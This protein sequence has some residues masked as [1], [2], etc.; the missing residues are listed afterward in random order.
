LDESE[1]EVK[2]SN[3]QVYWIHA[4]N[5][6]S[7]KR[8]LKFYNATAANV[9]VGTTTPVLTFALGTQGDT[10]GAGFVLSVPNGIVFGTAITVA[11]TTGIADNDTGA[12]GANEVVLNIGYA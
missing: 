6:A 1:E 7:S 9:T 8:Y 4:M 12:P 5:L 11:A 2:A 3:G 10:N